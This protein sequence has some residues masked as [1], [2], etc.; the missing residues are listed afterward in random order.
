MMVGGLRK[1][2][3]MPAA[4]LARAMVAAGERAPNGTYVLQ[5]DEIGRYAG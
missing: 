5:F 3:P 2:R 1:Y 4:V